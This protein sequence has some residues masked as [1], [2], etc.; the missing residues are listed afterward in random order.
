LI[1]EAEDESTAIFLFCM[2]FPFIL[3][4]PLIQG[5]KRGGLY[6]T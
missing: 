1:S 3:R 6:P 5:Q 2:T 4:F